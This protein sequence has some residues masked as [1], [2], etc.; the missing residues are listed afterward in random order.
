MAYAMFNTS[1]PEKHELAADLLRYLQAPEQ[2]GPWIEKAFAAPTLGAFESMETWKDPKRAGF[3]EAAKNGVLAGHPGPITPAY[4]EFDSLMPSTSMVLRVI[5][6]GWTVDEAV[7][8][9]E[10]IA[11]DVYGKYA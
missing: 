4:A 8:E 2:Y 5:I 7:E 9:Q 11:N 6:D 1:A 3:L 10:Q